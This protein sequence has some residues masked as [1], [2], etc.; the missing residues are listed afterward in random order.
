MLSAPVDFR[1]FRTHFSWTEDWQC[2]QL[3]ATAKLHLL[4]QTDHY[5]AQ[6]RATGTVITVVRCCSNYFTIFALRLT[7]TSV[8]KAQWGGQS[9]MSCWTSLEE[10]LVFC[11]C[12]WSPIITVILADDHLNVA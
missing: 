2:D 6:I 8:E 10:V 1:R 9:V 5:T 11:K 7:T 12:F 4:H 3:A